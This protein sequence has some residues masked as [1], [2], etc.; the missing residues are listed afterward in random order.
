[1]PSFWSGWFSPPPPAPADEITEVDEHFFS[2]GQVLRPPSTDAARQA[3][4][5]LADRRGNPQPVTPGEVEGL[6]RVC[7]RDRQGHLTGWLRATAS[8]ADQASDA[9]LPTRPEADFPLPDIE[10]A[11]TDDVEAVAE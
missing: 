4:Q 5:V 1:M 6:F 2:L 8:Q 11:R 3:A 9:R 10:P 7:L